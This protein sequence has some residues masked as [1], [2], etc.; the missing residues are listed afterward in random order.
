MVIIFNEKQ[1]N[2]HLTHCL[3]TMALEQRFSGI[4]VE[5]LIFR[6]K[7]FSKSSEI[8]DID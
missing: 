5:K 4:P 7:Y 3:V 6:G 1:K 8:S 2:V